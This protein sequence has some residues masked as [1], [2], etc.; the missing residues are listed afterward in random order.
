MSSLLLPSGT[1]PTSIRLRPEIRT[2][3]VES[4][5]YDIGRRIQEMHPTVYV[6]QMDDGNTASWAVME[7][8]DDGVQRLVFKTNVL[9]QR[10]LEKLAWIMHVPFEKRLEAAEKE[11]TDHD[12]KKKDDELEKLYEEMGRPMLT[13]LEHDGFIQRS[14]SYAKGGMYGKRR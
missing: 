5:L 4:D 3:V 8:C 1:L 11:V 7:N 10:V 13:Q 6:L 14:T 12:A 9:D 2:S